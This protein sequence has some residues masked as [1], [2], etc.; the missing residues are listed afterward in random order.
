MPLGKYIGDGLP[1]CKTAGTEVTNDPFFK[2]FWDTVLEAGLMLFDSGVITEEVGFK[3]KN[4][5]FG[6]ALLSS[7]MCAA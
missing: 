5:C 3:R 6:V 4:G 7:F 1:L 2:M